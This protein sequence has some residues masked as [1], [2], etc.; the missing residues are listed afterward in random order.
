MDDPAV[1]PCLVRGDS[2]FLLEHD[3]AEA[4]VAKQC[5]PGDREPENPRADDDE[6]R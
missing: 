2:V 6:I 1:V 3:D 4:L 5:L